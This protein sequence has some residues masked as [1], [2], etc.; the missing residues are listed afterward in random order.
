MYTQVWANL[1]L[2]VTDATAN[3]L[4]HSQPVKLDRAANLTLE[5]SC[6]GIT[7]SSTGTFLIE[8]SN[9]LQTWVKT[10]T[11]ATV[12]S[13]GT[14]STSST[15]AAVSANYIRVRGTIT[16]TGAKWLFS[17]GVAAIYT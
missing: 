11:T 8:T 6:Q 3:A 12:T 5:V 2:D 16:G 9:D 1:D 15:T 7:A 4:D 17:V 13:T 10:G 14:R